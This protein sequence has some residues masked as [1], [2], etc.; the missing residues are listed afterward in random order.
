MESVT[1]RLGTVYHLHS[2]L[3]PPLI[4]AWCTAVDGCRTG[5]LSLKRSCGFLATACVYLGELQDIN[6]SFR[7]LSVSILIFV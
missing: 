1:K 7:L 5:F 3:P 4:V 6:S 2:R